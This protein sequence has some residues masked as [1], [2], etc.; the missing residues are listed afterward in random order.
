VTRLPIVD[1]H[2]MDKVLLSLGFKPVRQ[3]AA[4][5]FTASRMAA[6]PPCRTIR[7]GTWPGR[8][9]GKSYGK[10]SCRRTGFKKCY[11]ASSPQGAPWAP[12]PMKM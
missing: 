8:C 7:A 3:R 2:T 9:P 12:S 4:M 6:P 10:M 5:S 11:K 1:C